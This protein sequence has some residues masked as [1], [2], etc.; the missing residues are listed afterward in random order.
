MSNTY[1]WSTGASSEI[2][3]Y[4]SG[5]YIITAT[6]NIG[7]CV[8]RDTINVIINQLPVSVLTND[9]SSCFPINL[10]AFIGSNYLYTWQ[11]GSNSSELFI[12]KAVSML[13]QLKMHYRLRYY[14]Y[15]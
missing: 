14:G 4:Q 5:N 15:C 6:S 10:N 8:S 1:V 7:S 11:N 13:F 3:V 2:V 9:T 12:E